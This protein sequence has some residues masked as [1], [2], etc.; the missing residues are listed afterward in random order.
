MHIKTLIDGLIAAAPDLAPKLAEHYADYDE[1]LGHLFFSHD[2]VPQIVA[3]RQGSDED[4]A[5]LA[6]MLALMEQAWA[7]EGHGHVDSDTVG[8]IAL[9]VLESL[10]GEELRALRP[11]LGPEMGRAADRH[12]LPE[13]PPTLGQ[14]FPRRRDKRSFASEARFQGRVRR[15]ETGRIS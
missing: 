7:E 15:P 5:R 3:L 12:Y 11:M 9:S 14:P 2:V 13:P 6:A 8:V 1:L 4:R 10:D